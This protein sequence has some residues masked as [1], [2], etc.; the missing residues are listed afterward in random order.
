MT[1]KEAAE[2]RGYKVYD[3]ALPQTWVDE[4][5]EKGFDVRG[6]FVWSYDKNKFGE[7]ASIT[8]EGDDWINNH[9]NK[10]T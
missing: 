10:D 4:Q 3:C 6:H 2:E 9:K 8:A 1:V 7:S 5:R